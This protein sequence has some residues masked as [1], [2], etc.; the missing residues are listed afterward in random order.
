M[1][2]VDISDARAHFSRHPERVESDETVLAC[3]RNVQIA[4]IRPVPGP[5]DRPRPVG[6]DRG[7]VVPDSFFERLP[8]DF[9]RT[10]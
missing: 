4:E 10:E 8:D 5:P 3:R 1:Y 9:L 7:M 6:I 2:K